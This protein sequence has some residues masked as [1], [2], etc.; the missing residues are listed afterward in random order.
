LWGLDK[1]NFGI[2]SKIIFIVFFS[3]IFFAGAKIKERSKELTVE[4]DKGGF[5]SFLFDSFSLPFLRL[6]KWL[7]GQWTKYNVVLVIITALIDMPFQIFTEFLEQW[8]YFVKEKKEEI[9]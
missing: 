4:E 5:F 6:G 1:L 3:L 2:L 7:S 8:R 9:R